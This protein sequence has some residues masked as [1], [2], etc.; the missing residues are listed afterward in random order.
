MTKRGAAAAMAALM[1][2][3]ML[4][5]CGSTGG[6]QTSAAAKTSAAAE[7][8]TAAA[9][10]ASGNSSSGDVSMVFAWWGN[11]TRNERTQN[12]I[13]AY[14]K[15]NPGVTID[16][17][18]SEWNDYWQKMATAAAGGQAPDIMQQDYQYINQYAKSG[19]LLDL[20]PY[21]DNGTLD[22]SKWDKNMLEAGTVDGKVIAICAGMNAPALVYNKTITDEAGVTIKDNMT[23][24]EFVT[25]AKTIYEKTGYKTDLSYGTV[26]EPMNYLLRSDGVVLF[27]DG[28][29]NATKEQLTKYFQVYEDGI[30]EGWELGPDV[31]ADITIG[32]IEQA[33]IVAGTSPDKSAWN[34]LMWSN[35]Y[36]A[37]NKL[38]KE[39]MDLEMTT[40]PS[41]D[42]KKS[43]FIKPGQFFSV[44]SG[45]KNPEEAVKFLNYLINSTDCNDILLGERG[46]PINSDVADK[47]KSQL[48]ETDQKIYNYIYN[49]VQP[50]CSVINPPYPDGYA[51][52]GKALNNV[53]EELCYGQIDASQAAE[54]FI[55]QGSAALAAKAGS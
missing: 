45:T 2:V 5:G 46:V 53:V 7:K 28:K 20:K 6:T 17:Q 13:E 18:F 9:S 11:Q 4:A 12:A 27:G 36:T 1:G 48:D 41:P 16:G 37:M 43:D 10:A 22:A 50:N 39:G 55:T 34:T 26:Q 31:Y 15:D 47:I 3:G 8:T 40:W 29:L 30:K 32:S 23:L 51:E 38:A 35:Q 33:P 44:T 14:E 52:A 21:I 54:E 19:Q 25:A 42:P 49:V 24:D